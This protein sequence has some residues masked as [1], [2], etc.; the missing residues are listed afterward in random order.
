MWQYLQINQ[1]KAIAGIFTIA[2][3]STLIFL[4]V[5]KD[6]TNHNEAFTSLSVEKRKEILTQMLKNNGFNETWDFLR[7]KKYQQ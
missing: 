3:L 6:N 2:F 7:K 4:N 5:Q 1:K